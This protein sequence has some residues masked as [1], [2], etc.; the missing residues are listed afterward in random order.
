MLA[1]RWKSGD[2]RDRHELLSALFEKL[3]VEH[4]QIIGC[5][6]RCDR[7][8]RVRM[9]LNT[10]RNYLDPDAVE[11]RDDAMWEAR[12]RDRGC[13]ALEVVGP[14]TGSSGSASRRNFWAI[15]PV[16]LPGSPGDGPVWPP[17]EAEE[18]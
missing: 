12:S 17:G 5:T 2:E 18:S 3:H 10:A 15:R 11:A 13:V 4:G 1:A 7:V 14:A 6:P 16:G 9:L 8:N